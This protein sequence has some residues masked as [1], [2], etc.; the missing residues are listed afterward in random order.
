MLALEEDV[1]AAANMSAK[2]LNEKNGGKGFELAFSPA[3]NGEKI[4]S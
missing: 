3:A 4:S 2:Q 1:P